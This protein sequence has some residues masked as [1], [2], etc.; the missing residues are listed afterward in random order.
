[1]KNNISLIYL[2]DDDEDDRLFFSDAF[3]ETDYSP[4][5]VTYDSGLKMLERLEE[6]TILP[7]IIFVDLNMPHISGLEC[8]KRLKGNKKFENISVA[9]YSTSDADKDVGSSYKQ[10]ANLY[11]KKQSSF[12]DIVKTMNIVLTMNW[13]DHNSKRTE[14]NFVLEVT[15]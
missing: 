10:G 6:E 1:M 3:A 14:D 2:V 7:E 13:K 11:I 12:Q 4:E 15:K 9:I 5:I 8:L